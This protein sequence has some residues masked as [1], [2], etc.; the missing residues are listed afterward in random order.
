MGYLFNLVVVKSAHIHIQKRNTPTYSHIHTNTH[1]PINLLFGSGLNLL[2]AIPLA[3]P[4]SQLTGN[5]EAG[6]S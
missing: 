5:K 2:S 1:R 4:A 6:V 3:G